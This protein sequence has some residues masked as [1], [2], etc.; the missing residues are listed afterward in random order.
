METR[1]SSSFLPQESRTSTKNKMLEE[2]KQEEQ[3]M[4][5][6]QRQQEPSLHPL[7]P[8]LQ[9]RRRRRG[10]LS[11]YL[12][13][14]GSSYGDDYGDEEDEEDENDHQPV[15]A[16]SATSSVTTSSTTKSGSH[17]LAQHHP[18]NNAYSNHYNSNNNNHASFH[19]I[20]GHDTIPIPL[21]MDDDDHQ[22]HRHDNISAARR[23][24]LT[25]TTR[26]TV[27][28]STD[29]DTLSEQDDD[30][31]EL[32]V[33]SKLPVPP[34][35]L[36]ATAV[37]PHHHNGGS[38]E[39]F[40]LHHPTTEPGP[41][42]ST[43]GSSTSSSS[44]TGTGGGYTSRSTTSHSSDHHHHHFLPHH[45]NNNSN[46]N[47]H[48]NRSS[49]TDSVTTATATTLPDYEEQAKQ[50]GIQYT[51][52]HVPSFYLTLLLGLQNA[53]TLFGG[54]GLIPLTIVPLMGG[55]SQQAAQ[56]I[57]TIAVVTGCNTLLQTTLGNRLP[58]FQVPSFA[59]LPPTLS[60]IAHPTL[61]AI[62]DPSQRFEQT[63]QVISG[64]VLVTGSVQTFLGYSGAIV[65]L[66]KYISPITI[67]TV[68]T[69]IGLGYYDIGFANVS[70]CFPMGITMM[71][72]A[73]LCSQYV[74]KHMG[75]M[76]TA[77]AVGGGGAMS[78]VM[79]LISLFPL[80]VAMSFTWSLSAVL[81][82]NDFFEEDSACRTDG[83]SHVMEDMPFF[84]IP[85]PGQWHGFRFKSYAIVPMFG[86]MMASMIESAGDYYSCARISGAP[87]P[88]PGIISRG[89]AVEGIGVM[90]AGLFGT[91]SG[92]TSS[93][94]NIGVMALTGVGS[95][96]VV[97]MA[98]I[99]LIIVGMMGKASAT[100]AALPTGI[101][102]GMFCVVLSVL[103]AVGLS[104]LQHV[105]L[106]NHRNLFIVGFAVF[107]SLSIAGPGGYFTKKLAEEEGGGEA[108]FGDSAMGQIALALLTSPM[109][110]A[111]LTA[112]LMDNTIPGTDEDRGL[113]AWAH[114]QHADVH[115]DPQY[116]K[117]YSLPRLAAN[118]FHNCGYLELFHRGTMPHPPASGEFQGGRGDLGE[119]CCGAR[120]RQ[121]QL[122]EE[123]KQF[124]RKQQEHALFQKKQA[125]LD[126]DE[127]GGRRFAT[128]NDD[129]IGG[130]VN[131]EWRDRPTTALHKQ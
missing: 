107:F 75:S 19:K 106:N 66:L 38:N 44:G 53:V 93:T 65:P 78:S 117:V 92:S 119:L 54:L 30:V 67:A 39:T 113:L 108:P 29:N 84:R 73:V 21:R 46:N 71:F 126:S 102:G 6:Q 1:I 42:T 91:G 125:V 97:Q 8:S 12:L 122:Q 51:I 60:I 64:A 111:L 118:L 128:Q 115:N 100:L 9:G 86:A 68:I 85:F 23:P 72:L 63:M 57:G 94:G 4:L 34:P 27:D 31:E 26:T 11:G 61:Q 131:H 99:L 109:V 83:A 79:F 105:A 55:T 22:H 90:T 98:S 104:S 69:T 96:A 5:L 56:V 15:V 59:Y 2:Q 16:S 3:A 52:T 87:P 127:E 48:T 43:V 80:L 36:H 121:Q 124:L 116:V 35:H 17:A 74:K 81:T 58:I 14:N 110:I 76:G 45:H 89:L 129:N 112:M 33:I 20:L 32:S 120:R 25:N 77:A 24:R 13:P 7:M 28:S 37:M 40:L 47:N 82:A 50:Q 41:T 130:G 18:Q 62:S 88:S 70:T 123:D 49:D 95:R 114:A 103:V 101:V 10:L